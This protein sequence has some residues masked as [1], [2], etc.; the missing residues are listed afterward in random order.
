MHHH[1]LWQVELPQ[2]PQ[3]VHPLLGFLGEGADVQLPLEV[4]GNDGTQEAEGLHR[5]NWGVTQDDEGEWV[6]PQ[7]SHC[8]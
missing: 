8:F 7:S 6:L 2:L 4:L 1:R 3:E 5:V